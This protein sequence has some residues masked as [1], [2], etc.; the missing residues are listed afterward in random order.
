LFFPPRAGVVRR[1]CCRCRR[2]GGSRS[3]KR[4]GAGHEA[5]EHRGGAY[6]HG[7]QG[8]G[9]QFT[10]RHKIRG[11]AFAFFC[12]AVDRISQRISLFL[13]LFVF[14]RR[15]WAFPF[16]FPFIFRLPRGLDR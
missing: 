9:A 14:R 5:T 13:S 4:G 15:C 7:A 11:D 1:C 3:I 8:R 6:S 10:E 12:W 2:T 16:S